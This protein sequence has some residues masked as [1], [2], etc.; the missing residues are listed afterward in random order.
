M[1]HVPSNI[2]KTGGSTAMA[3]RGYAEVLGVRERNPNNITQ[4]NGNHAFEHVLNRRINRNHRIQG[5]PIPNS[6]R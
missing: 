6:V 2:H 1:N 3:N 5:N 4:W